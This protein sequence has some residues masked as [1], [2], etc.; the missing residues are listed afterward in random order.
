MRFT[1]TKEHIYLS[2]TTSGLQ[3][4]PQDKAGADEQGS[5]VREEPRYIDAEPPKRDPAA[6]E[7][8]AE[9]SKSAE[10]ERQEA[11]HRP[12]NA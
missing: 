3:L 10:E 12:C 5:L 6:D 11:S 7:V 4:A 9:N 8:K 1:S 2:C